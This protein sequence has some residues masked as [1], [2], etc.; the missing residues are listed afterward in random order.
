MGPKEYDLR[1]R[2]LLGKRQ[3]FQF[4]F[5]YPLDPHAV[6]PFLFR[7]FGGRLSSGFSD[8]TRCFMMFYDVFIFVYCFFFFMFFC[9]CIILYCVLFTLVFPQGTAISNRNPRRAF[10]PGPAGL[11]DSLMCLFFFQF[12]S[13]TSC[14]GRFSRGCRGAN[15]SVPLGAGSAPPAA[16]RHFPVSGAECQL[17][18]PP[19]HGGCRG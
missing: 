10:S 17:R 2:E 5:N 14:L 1:Q 4:L 6:H 16:A 7:M 13:R 12:S 9:I 3:W 15:L 19:Y 11:L 18:K 8:S